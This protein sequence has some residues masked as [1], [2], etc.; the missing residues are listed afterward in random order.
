MTYKELIKLNPG[1]NRWATAPYK[2]F[3]LLIP[4]EKVQAFS[5]NL[6]LVP[7]DKRVNFTTHQ[8]QSGDSLS[9]I[10]ARYHT[11]VNLIKQVNQLTENQVK[12]HQAILIPS[13]KNS[14]I[15]ANKVQ[16]PQSVLEHPVLDNGVHRLIHIVQA[17]DSYQTLE[18][19]YAVTAQDIQKWNQLTV[20]KPLTKGQQL[21][22]FKQVRKPKEYIVQAGDSLSLIAQKHQTKVKNILALNPALA[23]NNTIKLGQK[24]LVG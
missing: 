15:V 17:N 7:Q 10:A 16:N 19:L 1:F 23:K 14:P 6:A 11:T 22:I 5:E 20:A 2:P 4:T 21:V 18:K 12:P 9:N 24:I 3:R 13:T 8:V